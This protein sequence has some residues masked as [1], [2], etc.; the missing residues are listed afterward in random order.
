MPEPNWL[1]C[2]L[3]SAGDWRGVEYGGGRFIAF[4]QSSNTGA[5]SDNRG[6][7]WRELTFPTS[8]FSTIK[9]FRGRWYG[10]DSNNGTGFSSADGIIW[11]SWTLPV[12]DAGYWRHLFVC[13]D[14]MY[15]LCSS[16]ETQTSYYTEDGTNWNRVSILGGTYVSMAY[17]NNVY[18]VCRN[19]SSFVMYSTDG[20]AFYT[21]NLSSGKNS[22]RSVTFGNGLFVMLNYG[23]SNVFTSENGR[24]WS[25]VPVA[26]ENWE[27]VVYGSGTFVAVVSQTG[28][29][30]TYWS[31]NGSTWASSNPGTLGYYMTVGYG[32][33]V[34]VIVPYANYGNLSYNAARA[35]FNSPPTTPSS[36][37]HGQP[38]AGETLTITTG[39]S[40]DIDGDAVTY[41]WERSINGGSF[42]QIASG[43]SLTITDTV[44]TSGVNIQYRVKAQDTSGAASEYRTGAQTAIYYNQPPEVPASVI[45]GLP[46]A[47]KTLAITCA[48]VTDPE[49]DSITYVWERSIDGGIWSQI[50][51]TSVNGFIDTVPNIGTTYN[52]RVKAVD[53]NGNESGY[54]VG[55]A[56]N[57]DYNVPPTIT[58][59]DQNMGTVSEPFSYAYTVSDQDAED[60][61]TVVEKLDGAEIKRFTA[62]SGTQYAADFSSKWQSLAVGSHQLVIT[63]TDQDGESATRTITFSRAVTRIAAQ[64]VITLSAMPK[65]VFLSL[66][67][68]PA[69][70]TA[71]ITCQVCNNP[72]DSSPAWEDI[73]GK[74]NNLVHV[75][76]NETATATQKGLAYRFTITPADGQ[77]VTFSTAVV[78]YV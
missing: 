64:R 34:F 68:Q 56:Q 12:P 46:K 16:D 53:I 30:S 17:G 57:I 1:S 50:G 38:K 44:P 6:A 74:I 37:T 40:T 14:R 45:F 36:I 33:G 41:V 52:V 69:A 54:R 51:I 22:W 70:G 15:M 3:P 59:T 35:I 25:P 29:A 76:T 31:D 5:Y 13:N 28:G 9:Y 43:S 47:G 58:G 26:A 20:I 78:R 48:A 11:T 75:F 21:A 67:P 19:T 2:N 55:T 65:K 62:T 18:V 24:Q 8:Y 77:T 23:N 10:L 61:I 42:S 63:A 7:T 73:S 66:F 27:K 4:K 39:G 72:Y 49:S 71:T 60:V 32:D